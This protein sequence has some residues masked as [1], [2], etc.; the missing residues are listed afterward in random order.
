VLHGHGDVGV[1]D[2]RRPAAEHLV[3]HDAQGVDVGAA[4]HR[5]V[6]DLLG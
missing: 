1:A 3:E 5:R 6:A 4:V 2:E